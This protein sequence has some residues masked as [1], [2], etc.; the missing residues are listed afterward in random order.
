MYIIK[1][2]FHLFVMRQPVPTTE[3]IDPALGKGTAS[4]KT[5]NL[6]QCYPP[7]SC[8]ATGSHQQSPSVTSAVTSS[9]QRSLAIPR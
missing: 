1:N 8:S 2:L 9:H 4:H 6:L 5:G 3:P 7:P